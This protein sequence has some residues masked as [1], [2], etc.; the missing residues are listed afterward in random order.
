MKA[1]GGGTLQLHGIDLDNRGGEI[2]LDLNSRLYCTVAGKGVEIRGGTI[3]GL[4]TI[5]GTGCMLWSVTLQ[6]VTAKLYAGDSLG[7]SD[8]SSLTNNGR[9]ELRSASGT[10]ASLTGSSITLD[11][12]GKVVFA[13]AGNN[14]IGGSTFTIGPD[15]TITTENA[16][17]GV[18]E[19]SPLNNKGR[20]EAVGGGSIQI[21]SASF[22][23]SG[24]IRVG[25]GST[26]TFTHTLSQTAGSTWVDGQLGA[27]LV[28][29][30]GG[31]LGG[32]GTINAPVNL[33]GRLSPGSTP[34][35]LQTGAL[36]LAAG[37]AYVWEARASHEHDVVNVSGGL[38]IPDDFRLE[39]IGWGDLPTAT[40]FAVFNYTGTLS[41][42]PSQWT[43]VSPDGSVSFS[44]LSVHDNAI[45]IEDVTMT[46][47]VA[48]LRIESS[49][50]TE[51]ILS[52][53]PDVPG[54]VLQE[55]EDLISPVWTD[56]ASGST[57][58]VTIPVASPATFY[59][60][61]RP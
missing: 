55:C 13:A 9:I 39:L 30:K 3:S 31:T 11:G 59:R 44:G 8:D 17:T 21:T 28:D 51:L 15:Q 20:I 22:A 2:A 60:L 32:S 49:G 50:S 23:N 58:P 16:G 14:R 10:A 34:G 56:T 41:A 36:T 33:A 48:S 4:G 42:D 45:W 54:W 47:Q 40:D 24:H 1:T 12:D 35:A 61:V 19:A 25:P 53:T 37:S 29:I 18:I 27:P 38:Q 52:W 46:S 6:N 7:I 26:G 5:D 57:N 43:V